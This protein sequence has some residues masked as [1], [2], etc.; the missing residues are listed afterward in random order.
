MVQQ[1]SSTPVISRIIEKIT[2]GGE[3]RYF[4]QRC[5]MV[6][7][8]YKRSKLLYK[9]RS[10]W[11]DEKKTK[12]WLQK[13]FFKSE[14]IWSFC[15][16][17]PEKQDDYGIE[18]ANDFPYS[19]KP[20]DINLNEKQHWGFAAEQDALDFIK[21]IEIVQEKLK[22]NATAKQAAL[23]DDKKTRIIEISTNPT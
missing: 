19:A 13:E 9:I 2:I 10:K 23:F 18:H 11:G 6:L 16:K 20:V 4:V 1:F 5:W 14:E 15:F 8:S 12:E 3:K 7:K 21:F 17:K 22:N